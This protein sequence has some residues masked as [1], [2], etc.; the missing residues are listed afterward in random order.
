MDY[1]LY[2]YKNV[3]YKANKV[4]KKELLK[5]SLTRYFYTREAKKIDLDS[6][7]LSIIKDPKGKPKFRNINLN[8]NISHSGN[9]WATVI[10]EGN[11]GLDIQIP[12]KVSYLKIAERSF[13]EEVYKKLEAVYLEEIGFSQK[14]KGNTSKTDIYE[15]KENI[16]LKKTQEVF[17]KLWVKKEAVGKFSGKGLS[18]KDMSL[19]SYT[20]LE[21][22]EIKEP[23]YVGLC[24]E[25]K[26]PK[27]T[28]EVIDLEDSKNK[29]LNSCDESHE[30]M[31][32]KQE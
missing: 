29:E 21:I 10:G 20:E 5:E 2:L 17:F 27:L 13:S 6:L 4:I 31:G 19:G 26:N 11:C 28:Y 24:L 8:F 15:L 16:E 14:K 12:T 7:D 32:N 22:S 1:C 3:N 18:E 9:Y 25:G 30:S 23:I